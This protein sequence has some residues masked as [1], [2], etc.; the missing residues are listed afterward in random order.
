MPSIVS[1]EFVFVKTV[2]CFQTELM[3]T[4]INVILI[5]F[6]N[7]NLYWFDLPGREVHTC[8]SAEVCQLHYLKGNAWLYS[9]QETKEF[10]ARN[11]SF[12]GVIQGS[13]H[14]ISLECLNGLLP[15]PGDLL[16]FLSN[17]STASTAYTVI[18]M[19]QHF[20][21]T[22]CS[23]F[24]VPDREHWYNEFIQLS[25]EAKVPAV[26]LPALMSAESYRLSDR[27]LVPDLFREDLI[28]VMICFLQFS[29]LK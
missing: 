26:Y 9:A 12:L 7:H 8:S 5:F 21:C 20:T 1:Q 23:S 28:L 19:L 25:L 27:P 17:F 10:H 14:C 6:F 4:W 29:F 15:G 22:E 16:C 18:Q 3:D 2:Y 11:C 24:P 13:N